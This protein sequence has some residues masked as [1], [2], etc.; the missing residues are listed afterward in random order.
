M[1]KS[2][3]GG[4]HRVFDALSFLDSKTEEL[5]RVALEIW[6]YSE[7]GF[8]EYKSAKAQA[9]YLAKYGFRINLGAGGI[10]TALVAEWG[11]GAP[12]IGFLGEYD[13]LAGLSQ[14]VSATKKPRAST[15][16][17]IP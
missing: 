1:V 11:Q 8:K 15:V 16:S 7:L 3:V 17:K 12:I 14:E 9:D 2:L 4:D 13:A 6:D 5:N 10:P